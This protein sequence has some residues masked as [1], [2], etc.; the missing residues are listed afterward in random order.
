MPREI[1]G[2]RF[3]VSGFDTY[4]PARRRRLRR[5]RMAAF[6]G[7]SAVVLATGGWYGYHNVIDKPGTPNHL[8]A[9][10]C[11]KTTASSA[12]HST[13]GAPVLSALTPGDVTVNVYNATT[14]TGLAAIT[15]N[16][17]KGRGFVI[18]KVAND[19]VKETVG[20]TALVRG[21]K[22]QLARMQLISAQV[23][24]TQEAFDTRTD[25]SVDLVLGN[26]YAAL[27]PTAQAAAMVAADVKADTTAAAA[28][29]V[30]S[31]CK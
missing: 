29:S 1:G 18:G 10:S 16:G 30:A 9:A 14:R 5:R 19:P 17:L 12:H 13:G 28:P 23:S 31:T 21:A 6:A 27:S 4:V 24:G 2:R 8:A 22:A 26:G 7:I 25:T 15:A 11:P 3:R 20:G